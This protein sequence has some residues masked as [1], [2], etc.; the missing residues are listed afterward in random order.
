MTFGTLHVEHETTVDRVLAELR[1][2][3]FDGELQPGTPLREIALAESLGVSRSTVREALG[4]LVAEGL[5]VRVPNRGTAVRTTDPQA[6]HDVSRART[7]LEVA[8]VRRWTEATE[9]QRG[10]VRSALS[11]YSELVRGEPSN[12]ELNEAHLAIHRSFVGLTGSERLVAA[13]DALNA[14]I[15]LALASVDRS[16][17]NAREQL[18]SHGD[19]VKLLES[20]RTEEAATELG[21]HLVHAEESMLGALGLEP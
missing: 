10:E 2:A 18:H 7:V 19:L 21:H 6:I 16:R 17:R 13:A 14:E 1:R 9:E 20:G 5:A 12:A 4:M 11:T 3:L 15:R 8:G